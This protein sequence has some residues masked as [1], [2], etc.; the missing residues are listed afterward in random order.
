VEVLVVSK[1]LYFITFVLH[2]MLGN[3]LYA[4]DPRLDTDAGEKVYEMEQVPVVAEE[5][6]LQTTLN[7]PNYIV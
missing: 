7:S 3:W 6:R 2:E 1:S 4:D 5:K